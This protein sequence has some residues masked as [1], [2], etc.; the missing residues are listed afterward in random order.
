L[1][2]P[3]GR[4]EAL[5]EEPAAARAVAVVCRPRRLARVHGASHLP[6]EDLP[7]LVREA[8]GA[9]AGLLEGHP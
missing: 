2:G 5:R 8:E 9:F 3:A 1:A 6:V 4:L 7:S